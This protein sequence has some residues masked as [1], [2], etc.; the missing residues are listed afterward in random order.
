MPEAPYIVRTDADDFVADDLDSAI[1][2]ASDYLDGAENAPE[3]IGADGRIVFDPG[4]LVG[5]IIEFRAR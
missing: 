4:E 1:S 2:M 5:K 3:V